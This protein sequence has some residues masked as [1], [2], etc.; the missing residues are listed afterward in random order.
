[1]THK[2]R[3]VFGQKLISCTRRRTWPIKMW[4]YGKKISFSRS[5]HFRVNL[6]RRNRFHHWNKLGTSPVYEWSPVRECVFRQKSPVY[7]IYK[8]THTHTHTHTHTCI[9]CKAG[10]HNLSYPNGDSFINRFINMRFSDLWPLIFFNF[11]S[12]FKFMQFTV[13]RV[14]TFWCKLVTLLSHSPFVI[15]V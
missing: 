15:M 1:M 3:R 4:P 11:N 2:Y 14:Q 9:W 7:T 10:T 12:A 13:F 8:N 6:G 5:W